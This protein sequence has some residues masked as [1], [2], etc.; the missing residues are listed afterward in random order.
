MDDGTRHDT[1]RPM[2]PREYDRCVERAAAARSAHELDDLRGEV[3]AGWPGDARAQMLAE[4]LYEAAR[5]FG[6]PDDGRAATRVVWDQDPARDR[7]RV[8]RESISSPDTV[9]A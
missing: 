8:S 6:A 5:T 9:P 7:R 1:D 4:A 3:R 2:T